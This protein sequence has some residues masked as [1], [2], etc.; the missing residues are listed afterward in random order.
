MG[1]ETEKNDPHIRTEMA[2]GMFDT[3]GKVG[4]VMWSVCVCVCVCVCVHA[5]NCMRAVHVWFQAAEHPSAL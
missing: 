4:Y 5:R 1:V 2:Y 3:R